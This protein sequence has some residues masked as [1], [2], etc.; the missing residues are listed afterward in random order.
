MNRGRFWN[1]AL[2]WGQYVGLF[3]SASVG[4]IA[5][6]GCKDPAGVCSPTYCSDLDQE[7]DVFLC[8]PT[9]GFKKTGC[10][11]SEYEANHWCQ[12]IGGG[13]AW[14]PACDDYGD[15]GSDTGGTET[16]GAG[17]P[18]WDPSSNVYFDR[19]SGKYWINDALITMVLDDVTVLGQDAT[20]VTQLSTGYFQ[21]QNVVAGDLAAALGLRTGDVLINASGNDLGSIDKILTAADRLRESTQFELT[22][23]RA[24][25]SVRL[26][27]QVVA[28]VE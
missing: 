23:S 15:G 20:Y 24:G 21:L 6:V 12:G 17:N 28:F 27:Y 2:R 16:G 18:N 11:L 13:K 25:R 8:K 26:R 7:G 1:P 22:V 19:A 5:G 3:V 4:V 14:R 9:T 10:F